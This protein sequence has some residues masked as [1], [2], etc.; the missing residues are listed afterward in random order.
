MRRLL[1][2]A[3]GISLLYGCGG[4]G[5]IA[6]PDIHYRD[7]GV[8]VAVPSSPYLTEENHR[9]GWGQRDCLGCH[10]NFKHTMATPKFSADEYQG[11]I[12]RAV[13]NVG[14]RNSIE[15]CSACHGLNGVSGERRQCLVCH[16]Q[17]DKLHFYSNTSN[18]K[19]FHDF[20]GNGKIDDDD[21]VVCHW[22]PDMDGIVEMDTDFGKLGGTVVRN[23]QELC[24]K[25]HSNTWSSI[26]DEP[27]ADTN[28][29]GI[30][31]KKVSENLN[32][33]NVGLKWSGDYHGDNSF[34]SEKPFKQVD[35]DGE[36]LFH[37]EHSPLECVQCHNPHGSNNDGLI[38]EKVGET[39]SVV[40][41]VKQDDNTQEVKYAV[42]DPQT[43]AYFENMK[44]YGSVEAKDRTYNLENSTDL[45][46][47]VNLPVKNDDSSVENNRST[48]PSLCASCHDGSSDYS[49]VNGLGLPI[50]IQ[51]H[52]SGHKCIE[53][54]AHGGTF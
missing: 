5:G 24:L 44:Y 40:K 43:T 6:K 54:H 27:L 10:Q 1:L 25:C 26:K 12:D 2:I 7:F 8:N 35:L 49:S 11:L 46:D 48:S 29:D 16:D 14:V 42:I 34:S 53:C 9:D 17:M 45:N 28:G 50:D 51:N 20:N 32:P 47:Y 41:P 33:P 30:P 31:D 38:V 22:R 39:L 21:C 15:V 36:L 3:G 23:T 52:N 18:R 13:K 19:H 4:G 37:T